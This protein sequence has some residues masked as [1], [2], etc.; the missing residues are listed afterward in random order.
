[1]DIKEVLLV[2]FVNVLTKSLQLVVLNKMNNSLKN[3]INQLLECFFFFFK[4]IYHLNLTE[5]F[6]IFFL[7]FISLFSL[8][9]EFS[10]LC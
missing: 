9:L 5:I 3:H 6:L 1:M 8:I 10:Y 7:S 2:W 4:Y